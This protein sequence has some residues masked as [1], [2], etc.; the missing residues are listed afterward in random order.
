[1]QFLYVGFLVDHKDFLFNFLLIIIIF[2][3]IFCY[4]YSTIFIFIYC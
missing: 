4:N 2:R 3:L 1:M